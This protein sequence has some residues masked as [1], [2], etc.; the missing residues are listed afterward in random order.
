MT[1]LYISSML[2]KGV[3]NIT[4]SLL[5]KKQKYSIVSTLQKLYCFDIES[6][7]YLF[8]DVP[9]RSFILSHSFKIDENKVPVNAYQ[10]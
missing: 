6:R 5:L 8:K 1:N 9:K 2:D 7:R 4:D 3:L 10:N